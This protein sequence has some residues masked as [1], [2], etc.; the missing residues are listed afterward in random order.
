MK[1]WDLSGYSERTISEWPTYQTLAFRGNCLWYVSPVMLWWPHTN[2][3]KFA[4]VLNVMNRVNFFVVGGICDWTHASIRII[5]QPNHSY[6]WREPQPDQS[7][8]VIAQSCPFIAIP[9]FTVFQRNI[10]SKSFC[11]VTHSLIGVHYGQRIKC[12]Y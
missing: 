9:L 2:H 7:T 10:S 3:Y 5:L 1:L 8:F 12:R 11:V 4:F 6:M